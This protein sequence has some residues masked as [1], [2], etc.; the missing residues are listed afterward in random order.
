MQLL[1]CSTISVLSATNDPYLREVFKATKCCSLRFISISSR[2]STFA[3]EPPRGF[4]LSVGESD[5]NS[6]G[7]NCFKKNLIVIS[8]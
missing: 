2:L 4:M 1:V 6:P 5:L 3:V 8:S 7:T